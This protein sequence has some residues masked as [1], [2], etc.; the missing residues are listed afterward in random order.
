VTEPLTVEALDATRPVSGYRSGIGVWAVATVSIGAMAAFL[1]VAAQRLGYP[2]ELQWFEGRRGVGAGHRRPAAPRASV[3]RVHP[4]GLYPPL[5]FWVTAL[6]V[7]RAAAVAL[8]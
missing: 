6:A 8:L 7:A 3:D 1:V 5:Y 2:Y 4:R